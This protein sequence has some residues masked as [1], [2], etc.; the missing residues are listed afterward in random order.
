[1]LQAPASA[2]FLTLCREAGIH[3]TVETCGAVGW[4]AFQKVLPVT[5]LFYFDLKAHDDA[6]YRRLTG[7]RAGL[8]FQNATRLMASGAT[9]TFRMPVVANW[10]DAAEV[11]ENIAQFLREV[12]QP[13][14]RL[15]PYHRAGESKIE[16]L[17]S[18]QQK[19]GL[20]DH[21][22][23]RDAVERVARLFGQVG[24]QVV[25]EGQASPAVASK[26]RL[27]RERV[28]R[29]RKAV[30]SAAPA[31]CIERGTLVTEYFKN[32]HNRS[33]PMIV[34]KAEAL[35]Y[36]LAHRMAVIYD[37][38]LLVGSFTSKRVGGAVFPEL[39][40]VT[41]LEDLNSFSSRSV[42]PLVFSKRDRWRFALQIMPFWLTRFLT[43]RA[44]SLPKA[45]RFIVDQLKGERYVINETGG[46]AHFVPDYELLLRHGTSELAARARSL[47]AVAECAEEK[48]FYHAVEIV[49]DGLE[50]FAESYAHCARR[51]A[52]NEAEPQRRRELETIAQTCERVPRL[53]AITLQ[54]AF[55]SLLF[56]QIALN[57]ESLDNGVSPG[58]LDKLL[59]PYYRD[60]VAQGRLDED[61]AR[62]LVGCFT[63]K[64]NEMVPVFSSRVTRIHGGFLSG[65]AVVVGGR[66]ENGRDATN[67][68]SGMFLDA[69]DELRMRQPNYHARL[70]AQSPEHYRRRIASMLQRG[71]GA[72][73]LVND[74]AIVPMLIKR[75]TEVK[76]AHDYAPVGCVEPVACGATFGSTDA[77]LVNL[78]LSLEWALGTKVHRARTPPARECHSM[79]AFSRL[80][81]THIE[82]L[83]VTLLDD[84]QAIERA[85]AQYHPTPL[86][87]ML[88]RGCMES[89]CDASAGGAQYNGSGVQGVGLPD[90]A[91]S[92]AAIDE[93]VFRQRFCDLETLRVACARDFV[94]YQ[95]LRGRLLR[96][97]KFGND[98]PVVDS[99]ARMVMEAF[100]AAL[101]RHTNTRG[102]QYWAGFYSVTAHRAFGEVTGALPSGRCARV[103]LCSGLSPANGF[104]RR[105]PTASLNSV[106]T[107]GLQ[108]HARNGINVNLKLDG[109]SLDGTVG[110]QAIED[111]IYGYFAEGGMQVQMNVLDPAVLLEARNNPERY[112]GLLVRVSGYSAYF[113]DLAPEM[114]QEIIDRT[115]HLMSRA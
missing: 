109:T 98:D 105:G 3:T 78:A 18:S 45:L 33:K 61:G 77:A 100:S 62:E 53:G 25:I 96:A 111:L 65:Q 46:V 24:V 17:D 59:Y 104:D 28:W 56:A 66:D 6:T 23:N 54:Q 22:A 26:G 95:E 97:P 81:R 30:Q 9:V 44:F 64:M 85:N 43:L 10:N 40:G 47:G 86:T 60:D 75:G 71:S 31:I 89:G 34:Q 49:C 103:P 16:R 82:H 8:V 91:D 29:L 107:L 74:E 112:P 32:A 79:E 50:R 11:V 20:E 93:I 21:G 42:N 106:T 4:P 110:R 69:M 99:F 67:D 5:D 51:Q 83:V 72:P 101:G 36:V 115:L 84:L 52:R 55:Q 41:L 114:K 48:D 70:H 63:I 2:A 73:S 102:G 13:F 68:M 37:D 92:L 58:R 1:L 57:L 88:L 108:D 76:D 94:D 35:R 90:V 87:S 12:H 113:N 15:L 80:L 19:L 14:I 38:E 39:H 27:F 7:A